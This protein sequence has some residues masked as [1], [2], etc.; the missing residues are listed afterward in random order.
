MFGKL[1]E[2]IEYK[3]RKYEECLSNVAI[4]HSPRYLIDMEIETEE[5][6]FSKVGVDY[7]TLRTL[8]NPFSPI[9]DYFRS[10]L[11]DRNEDIWW[12]DQYEEKTTNLAVRLW[13]NLHPVEKENF[14]LLSFAYFPE[15]FGNNNK[16][17]K[18]LATWLASHHG[19][20]NPSL[21]DTF[22]SGGQGI[23]FNHS[24]PKIFIHL[25]E[26][27]NKIFKIVENLD[28][29]DI[30]FYWGIENITKSKVDIWL[31]L[32]ISYAK[33]QLTGEKLKMLSDY[34]R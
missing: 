13:S 26:H 28:N 8:P 7:D 10:K 23:I 34:L 27:K 24:F 4:T 30:N 33:D 22:T 5:T 14:R 2:P 16:K 25:K 31:D 9:K 12:I 17:Y 29:K 18:R 32:W 15:L 11:K 6:I 19:I 1:F 20:I 21:R 3:Y